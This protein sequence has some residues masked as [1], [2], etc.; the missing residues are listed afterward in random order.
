MFAQWSDIYGYIVW[1]IA[2]TRL[3]SKYMAIKAGCSSPSVSTL[4]V[5]CPDKKMA[6]RPLWL[7][8]HVDGRGVSLFGIDSA[9]NALRCV[10][11][12]SV[13]HSGERACIFAAPPP[14]RARLL[15][16]HVG[17][18]GRPARPLVPGLVAP[19]PPSFSTLLF[20]LYTTTL[21]SRTL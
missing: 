11:I 18:I 19:S 15:M 12:G 10:L 7:R 8:R 6:L 3:S 13:F 4:P 17:G 5:T 1:N 21:F 2:F 16:R 20:L 9:T 14:T